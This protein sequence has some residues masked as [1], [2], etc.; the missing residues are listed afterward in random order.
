MLLDMAR[1][2]LEDRF[3]RKLSKSGSGRSVAMTLPIELI[4]KLRWQRG[5]KVT[6][7]L[8]GKELVIKDWKK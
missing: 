2:K 3:T 6:I 7:E 1:N 8:R 5:Q 4:R